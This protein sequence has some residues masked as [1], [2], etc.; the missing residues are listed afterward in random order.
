MFRRGIKAIRLDPVNGIALCAACHAFSH[1]FSAH[2]TPE[3]FMRWF[4]RTYPERHRHLVK[5]QRTVTTERAAIAEF[6]ALL[7]GPR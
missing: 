6:E 2:K 3:A 1:A 4:K 7:D 5:K